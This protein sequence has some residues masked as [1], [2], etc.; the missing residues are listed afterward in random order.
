MT[1]PFFRMVQQGLFP[2]QQ[3]EEDQFQIPSMPQAPALP[4]WKPRR[5]LS[6]VHAGLL[7]AGAALLQAPGAIGTGAALGRALEAGLGSANA[8]QERQDSN[9]KEQLVYNQMA[10]QAQ[11]QEMKR[12]IREAIFRRFAPPANAT[13]EETRTALRKMLPYLIELGDPAVGSITEL[14]KSGEKGPITVAPG[15]TLVSPDGKP[16]YTAPEKKGNPEV[17]DL[18]D[19]LVGINPDGTVVWSQRKGPAPINPASGL[20]IAYGDDGQGYVVNK[21]T[22]EKT[23]IAGLS[24]LTQGEKAQQA[25][26]AK[27]EQFRGESLRAVQTLDQFKAEGWEPNRAEMAFAIKHPVAG[28]MVGH[29]KLNQWLGSHRILGTIGAAKF[30]SRAY[31]MVEAI[32]L[33]N[34]QNP[35]TLQGGI[36][37][38]FDSYDRLDA[39]NAAR[40]GGPQPVGR[41]GQRGNAGAVDSLLKGRTPADSITRRA[42]AVLDSLAGK[43]KP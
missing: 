25:T 9:A 38:I 1:M 6:P 15:A 30:G 17:R 5:G 18:G 34:I 19:R 3:E 20:E 24:H 29:D 39:R 13:Q 40:P 22:K 23:P 42:S 32:I 7:G 43:K 11:Q 8:A 35:A 26:D 2:P 31:Q 12:Q 14:L 28:L 10:A 21:I 41:L 4:P 33:A 16:I 37:D 27:V 36:A